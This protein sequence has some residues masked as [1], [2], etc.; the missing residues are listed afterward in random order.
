MSQSALLSHE[1][2]RLRSIR[3][4][5]RKADPHEP[6]LAYYYRAVDQIRKALRNLEQAA[7]E[8]SR[9][10]Q[11]KA[12]T[13]V[14]ADSTNGRESPDLWPQNWCPFCNRKFDGETEFNE[15]RCGKDDEK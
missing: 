14:P 6:A 12:A 11:R 13:T 9:Y 5:L 3:D 10:E 1:A 15:H 2:D 8:E 4:A 7:I